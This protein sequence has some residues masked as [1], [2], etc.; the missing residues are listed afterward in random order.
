MANPTV[1]EIVKKHLVTCGYDGLFSP[2]ECACENKDLGPCG[3]I[4]DTCVAGNFVSGADIMCEE[5]DD[6]GNCTE[7]DWHIGERK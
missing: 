7:H 6:D 5:A 2:G 4:R 3:E 1:A